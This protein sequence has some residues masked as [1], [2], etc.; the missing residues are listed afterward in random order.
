MEENLT[1]MLVETA[2]EMERTILH[3]D[4]VVKEQRELIEIL[5]KSEKAE[6]FEDFTKS[7]EEEIN[8]T[9]E[10]QAHLHQRHALL[11]DVIDSCRADEDIAK[12]VSALCNA[13][14]IFGQT[15]N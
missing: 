13:F 12:V 2:D 10:Q 7:I 11:V 14:G 4:D 9:L 3:I 1:F 5:R 8:N 15:N 6:K